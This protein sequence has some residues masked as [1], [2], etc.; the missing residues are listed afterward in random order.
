MLRC[1]SYRDLLFRPFFFKKHIFS[2]TSNNYRFLSLFLL[3]KVDDK[4]RG[5]CNLRCI[6][7]RGMRARSPAPATY[8]SCGTIKCNINYN[9]SS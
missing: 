4:I 3:L 2:I 5:H 9:T 7:H 1:N 6:D 8:G